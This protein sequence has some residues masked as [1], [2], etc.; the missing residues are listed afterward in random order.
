MAADLSRLP[1]YDRAR[2][3]SDNEHGPAAIISDN[4]LVIFD[5]EFASMESERYCL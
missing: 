5:G 1:V 2:S 3:R 4:M